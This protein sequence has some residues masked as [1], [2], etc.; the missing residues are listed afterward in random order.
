[1]NDP[2]ETQT[3]SPTAARK[4][5]K[6]WILIL[7]GFLIFLI[8]CALY[9]GPPV[10]LEAKSVAKREVGVASANQIGTA[11]T[12]YYHDYNTL[13]VPPT[14]K[15]TPGGTRFS[16]DTP[17]GL[18]VVNL[19]AGDN[20][21]KVKYLTFRDAKG[22]KDG[23]VYDAGG[24]RITAL[25]DPWG[26]PYFIVVDTNYDEKLTV[27]FKI[28]VFINGKRCVVYSAGQDGVFETNDDIKTWP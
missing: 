8:S 7:G 1:M 25:Y 26:N 5:P 18:E 9:F 20:P 28:P 23:A 17:E 19:L 4:R 6:K 11:V 22:R 10:L 13:P 12:S 15:G 16:T 2:S 3:G 14:T 27:P 24:S 21:R